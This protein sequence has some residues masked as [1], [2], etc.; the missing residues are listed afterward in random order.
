MHQP[1]RIL[2]GARRHA[3]AP[4][5]VRRAAPGPT[6]C[7]RAS[8]SPHPRARARPGRRAVRMLERELLPGARAR[9]S[10]FSRATHGPRSR[11]AGCRA[12]SATKCLPVLSPLGLDPAHPFPRILNKTLN[13]AVV[14][15]GQGRVRPRRPHG[16]A[17]VRRAR[18][19]A[20]SACPRKSPS[21]PYDFVFLSSILHAFVDELFPG[22]QVNGA[23]Q[24]RV[25]RNSELFVDEDEVE[26]LA[27]ALRD[28]LRGRGY[29]RA[30]GWKSPTRA[31]SRRR[32]ST[33]CRTSSWPR[34]T[35]TAATARS[36]SSASPRSTTWSIGR[37]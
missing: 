18:C 22:M 7:R 11:R 3:Q 14:L 25:T 19:R 29:V 2:R 10:A 9:A 27:L 34:A 16:D 5:R 13:I 32:R 1:R 28:E 4:P 21:A 23:Y 17:C 33:C 12:T 24:F 8:C 6:A 37:T 20:S 36:T 26:N 35:S 30:C 31:R 15:E